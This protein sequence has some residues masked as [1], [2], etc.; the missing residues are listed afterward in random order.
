M[1]NSFAGTNLASLELMKTLPFLKSYKQHNIALGVVAFLVFFLVYKGSISRTI[2]YAQA[3]KSLKTNIERAAS[4]PA[5]IAQL[6]TQLAGMQQS[7]LKP[8]DREK[9]LEVVTTFCRDNKV[10]VKTFPQAQL[11]K[12]NDSQIVT[13]KIVVE[14]SYNSIVKLV[15]LLEQQE[16]L[17][18]VSSLI[19]TTHKDRV[20]KKILLHAT[21]IFRNLKDVS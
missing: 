21:I 17:G 13:N 3:N 12:Q 11:T 4:A 8:Y 2:K 15:Y 5:E 14:G 9:L 1:E 7:A 20:S 6:Q 19:F 10:L 16:K 18:S